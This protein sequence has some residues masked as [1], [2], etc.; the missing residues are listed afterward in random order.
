MYC[1]MFCI[2]VNI[3]LFFKL[4]DNVMFQFNLTIVGYVMPRLG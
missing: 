2:H 3:F 1:I 4:G